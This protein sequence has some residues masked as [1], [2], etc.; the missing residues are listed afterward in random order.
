MRE[1]R[2][3]VGGLWLFSFSSGEEVILLHKWKIEEKLREVTFIIV[4]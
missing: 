4:G 2:G 3:G 1:T